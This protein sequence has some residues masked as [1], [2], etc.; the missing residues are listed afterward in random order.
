M[1]FNPRVKSNKLVPPPLSIP[2]TTPTGSG[3]PPWMNWFNQA[4]NAIISGN[5]LFAPA[6]DTYVITQAD[7][8]NL[9]NA[10][11]LNVLSTG[12]LKVMEVTGKLSSTGNAVIGTADLSN[13]G[14]IAG[15]YS[16][17]GNPVFVVGIDGRITAASNN[18]ITA[19][20]SGV[21]GGDLSNNYPNPTVSSINNS[22]LGTTTPTSGNLLVADGIQWNST[23]LNGAGTINNS[24]TLV[25]NT[26]YK[27]VGMD[28]YTYCGGM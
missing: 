26:V 17:N 8:T 21:A 4:Y 10:Q 19:A 28:T 22:L 3:T 16:I 11:V 15:T 13:T 20:P 9:P 27:T 6:Q 24:G 5:G 14:V 7:N 2:V 12:F 23:T 25:L 18:T 1:S